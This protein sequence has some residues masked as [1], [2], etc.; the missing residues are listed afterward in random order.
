MVNI[1]VK[2]RSAPFTVHINVL[3]PEITGFNNKAVKLLL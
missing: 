2:E 3:L 1:R